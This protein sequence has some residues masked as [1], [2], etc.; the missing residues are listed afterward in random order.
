LKRARV[1]RVLSGT[2]LAVGVL[3][4][5]GGAYMLFLAYQIADLEGRIVVP[6]PADTDEAE[7][8]LVGAATPTPLAAYTPTPVRG[9]S[10]AAV[11]VVALPTAPLA[12]PPTA[13]PPPTAAPT[14]PVVPPP[15]PTPAPA[16]PTPVPPPTEAPQPSP[17]SPSVTAMYMPV[18]TFAPPMLVPTP[19]VVPG[20]RATFVPLVPPPALPPP[21]LAVTP[22]IIVIL[23]PTVTP[24]FPSPPLPTAT[25]TATAVFVLPTVTPSRAAPPTPNPAPA[26]RPSFTVAPSRV[27]PQPPAPVGPTV[28]P[29]V[30]APPASAA[31]SAGGVLRDGAGLLTGESDGR[32][33]VWGGK[34]VVR[35]LLLG[36]DRREG[37]PARS[38]TMILATV[39]LWNGTVNLLSIPRDLVVSIPGY[40]EERVNA[41]FAF[42]QGA[43]PRDPAAGPALAV[44]TVSRQFGV[45]VDHY[46]F[47]DFRA[48]REIVDAVGGVDIT[49]A[50]P[51]DDY[52]YPTEDYRTTRLHFDAG[53]QHMDGAR[54]LAYARTRHGDDDNARRE[55]QMEVM[56]AVLFRAVEVD[57]VR[58]MP[59]VVRKLGDNMQT[60]LP[61]EAQVSLARLARKMQANGVA[62]YS[63]KPPMVSGMTGTRWGDVY[64]GDWAAIRTYVSEATDPRWRQKS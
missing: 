16:T 14:V 36:I 24:P 63:I 49:V 47:V 21:P 57:G 33:A 32:E 37:E 19:A 23:L 30:P 59:E 60:S 10:T 1:K 13:L 58:R 45:A 48:F 2:L 6:L 26:L 34:Q 52:A 28:L 20:M 18:P 8:A 53:R 4:V 61:Y 3:I 5:A 7:T 41:A 44:K 12:P 11:A 29:L 54:A 15:T 38:D 55:R 35:I 56:Q 43:R 42:G 9:R 17:T 40:G 46:L 27:G 31:P 62:Q 22:T 39:D 25:A 64:M 51:I 50:R